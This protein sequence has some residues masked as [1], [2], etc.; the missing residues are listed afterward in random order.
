MKKGKLWEGVYALLPFIG[1]LVWLPFCLTEN[2]WYD[3]AYTAAMVSLPWKEMILTTAHDVHSPFYYALLKLFYLLCGGGA[4]LPVLKLFSLLF[5]TGYLFLGKVTVAKLFSK[6]V[7]FYFLILSIL[8]PLALVQAGT[9]RMYTLALFCMTLMGLTAY[10]LLIEPQAEGRRGKWIL[11]TLATV[12]TMYSH[13]FAMIEAF[14]FYVLLLAA[15]WRA[16]RRALA[17]KYFLSGLVA[18]ILYLPWLAVT[19][20]QFLYR[21]RNDTGSRE[22]LAD[23]SSVRDC[24]MEWFS[25]GTNPSVAVVVIE[26]AVAIVLLS[27]AFIKLRKDG[28]LTPAIGFG[29]IVLTVA[30]GGI[31]S[32][33]VNNCFMGRY[34]FAGM[35]FFML[36]LAIGMTRLRAKWGKGVIL[37]LLLG[38]MMVSYRAE[39]RDEYDDGLTDYRAFVE[40]EV[41]AEDAIVCANYHELFLSVYAPELQYYLWNYK[42]AAI[43]FANTEVFYSADQLASVPGT[44]YLL[45]F[46]GESPDEV[47]EHYS[48]HEVMHFPYMYYDFVLYRLVHR[49]QNN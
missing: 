13:T 39:L 28:N 23:L 42:P 12:A 6:E 22:Q 37:A 20:Y 31:V 11:L 33:T 38:C 40:N 15:V 26:L 16:G 18:T 36:L 43:P 4:Y 24:L 2:L 48:Y 5:L 7:S 17:R 41:M 3:E 49:P 19:A 46:E 47:E 30:F 1:A 8:S 21:M 34:V 32:A 9:V 45:A 44:L 10:E 35:G 29:S 27:L 14:F 25:S